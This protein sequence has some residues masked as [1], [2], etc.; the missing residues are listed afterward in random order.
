MSLS[1]L[2]TSDSA[3]RRTLSSGSAAAS[4]PTQTNTC[5]QQQIQSNTAATNDNFFANLPPELLYNIIDMMDN[6][7][8]LVLFGISH[9][10]RVWLDN[11]WTRCE[12]N[13][14][15]RYQKRMLSSPFWLDQYVR[16]LIARLQARRWLGWNFG[17]LLLIWGDGGGGVL[18]TIQNSRKHRLDRT[19]Y[20]QGSGAN[21]CA[22]FG[23]GV[24]AAADDF[25]GPTA[26]LESRS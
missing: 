16:R 14:A 22:I 4:S 2:S 3:L 13:G 11:W 8:L 7:S 17:L 1:L 26:S 25:V 20:L 18:H 21:I 10:F 24:A 19:C 9:D 15:C 6:K 12:R 5:R 23:P